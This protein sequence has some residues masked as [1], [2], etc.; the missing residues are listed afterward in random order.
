M[1]ATPE[2]ATRVSQHLLSINLI[3][4]SQLLDRDIPTDHYEAP[5]EQH[6]TDIALAIRYRVSP[7][8]LGTVPEPSLCHQHRR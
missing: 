1:I 8:Q 3:E 5:N 4:E 6:Q 7:S 2:D